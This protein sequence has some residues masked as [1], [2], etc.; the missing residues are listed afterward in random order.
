[1]FSSVQP[2]ESKLHLKEID[3]GSSEH[4]TLMEMAFNYQLAILFGHTH[5]SCC[6]GWLVEQYH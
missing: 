5:A 1:M 2:P 3:K 4:L 6:K